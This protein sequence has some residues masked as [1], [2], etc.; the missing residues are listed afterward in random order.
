MTA[1]WQT[2]DKTDNVDKMENSLLSTLDA[3]IFFLGPPMGVLT[4]L[5]L[6]NMFPSVGIN[7]QYLAVS[8][9][10][11]KLKIPWRDVMEIRR[12]WYPLVR[13]V[14]TV[15]VRRL[16][17]FHSLFYGPFA[18][19]LSFRPTFLISPDIDGFDELMKSLRARS[20]CVDD[21]GMDR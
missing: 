8:F 16:A 4:G 10:F 1:D 11:Y 14:Y 6:A 19:F 2:V 15:R 5:A 17:P 7:P 9:C 18:K 20:Q 13:P 12:S 21:E 3:L